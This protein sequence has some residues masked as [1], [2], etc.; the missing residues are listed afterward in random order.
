MNKAP[1]KA[2]PERKPLADGEGNSGGRAGQA[3]TLDQFS[4]LAQLLRLR[5]GPAQEAARLVLVFGHAVGVAAFMAGVSTNSARNAVNRMLKGI[6]LVNAA[7][8]PHDTASANP[9]KI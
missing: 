6:K 1:E 4:A 3:M 7:S 2:K 9:A 8:L 5:T